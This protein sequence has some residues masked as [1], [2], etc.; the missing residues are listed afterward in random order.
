M[1]YDPENV[2]DIEEKTFSD[3]ETGY[4]QMIEYRDSVIQDAKNKAMPGIV[5]I[6]VKEGTKFAD[7]VKRMGLFE[8]IGKKINLVM[9]DHIQLCLI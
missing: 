2:M 7:K 5:P 8:L 4:D 3:P 9:A 6:T 1:V